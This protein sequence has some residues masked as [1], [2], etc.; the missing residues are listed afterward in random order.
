MATITN[1]TAREKLD[2]RREPY[3]LVLDK[4][5]AVG[6]RRGPDTWVARFRTPDLKQ[7]YHAL[8]NATDDY[9]KA[10]AAAE[11]WFGTMAKGGHRS[12]V[13]GTVKDA[14]DAYVKELREHGR[15][16]AADE[17][18]D[19]FKSV[20]DGARI[21]SQR[22]DRTTRQDF[23]DWREGLREGRQNRSV[24]RLVRGVVAALNYATAKLGHVGNK[25]AWTVT[26]LSDDVEE[27]GETA[28]FL[29]PDQRARLMKKASKP[30]RAY[31]QGLEHCGARPSELA[32]AKAA[33][34]DKRN[35]SL[36]LRHRKGRPPVLKP[37]AVALSPKAI[38]FFTAQAHGKAPDAP[39]IATPEGTHWRRHEWSRAIRAAIE[40]ANTN[41]PKGAPIIPE[42]ASAYSFRHA[43]ISEL[44]Q[45]GGVD[46]ITV[47][48]QTG[49]SFAMIEKFYFK[50][51]PQALKDKLAA[52]EAA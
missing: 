24:N 18:E 35:G 44:L 2:P 15:E 43:R 42:G 36:I 29:S 9:P 7:H 21:A 20:L 25:D 26:A 39:L 22:L 1:K 19:R 17:S 23:T 28:V 45:N 10:K 41:K 30:L 33:D 6:F 32:K 11:V 27:S 50:F 46:P 4:G 49:T 38:E 47:A 31:L 52:M 37:R 16:S 5:R 3:W 12:P 48:Q 34:F 13:K 14:L 40:A 51:I 8:G